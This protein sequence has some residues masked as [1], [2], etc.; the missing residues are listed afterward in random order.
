M[1]PSPCFFGARLAGA[2]PASPLPPTTGFFRG[3]S[4]AGPSA[5]RIRGYPRGCPSASRAG[6][7]KAGASGAVELF[8]VLAVGIHRQPTDDKVLN[9]RGI[10]GTDDSFN[11]PEF[12]DS[13]RILPSTPGKM[14]FILPVLTVSGV[15]CSRV[16][17]PEPAFLS[18]SI[19]PQPRSRIL[20]HP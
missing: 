13:E 11:A 10:Q 7:K 3:R 9:L 2:A 1:P 12:H 16:S 17:R 14:K 18:H 15:S 8:N 5:G 4:V 20:S 19:Q 6:W